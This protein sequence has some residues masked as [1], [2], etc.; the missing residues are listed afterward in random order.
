MLITGKAL[1][2][3]TFG[4]KV[5]LR[6]CCDEFKPLTTVYQ[7]A[8]ALG[9]HPET[10]YKWTRLAKFACSGSAV[11][12]IFTAKWGWRATAKVKVAAAKLKAIHSSEDAQ[13]AKTKARQVMQKLGAMRLASAAEIVAAGGMRRL[14]TSPQASLSCEFSSQRRR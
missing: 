8:K 4:T 14:V 9:R 11:G 3:I 13:A 6:F 10:L 5:Q 12:F 1:A 2:L 7:A